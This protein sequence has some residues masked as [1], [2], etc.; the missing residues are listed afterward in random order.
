MGRAWR[1][2]YKS[3]QRLQRIRNTM[4]RVLKQQ[5][6]LNFAFKKR[7]GIGLGVIAIG[8][9]ILVLPFSLDSLPSNVKGISVYLG[10]YLGIF[11][12]FIGLGVISTGHKFKVGAAGESRVTEVLAGF[13]KYWYIFND[14][15]V[16]RSQIDH[17]VVCPKGVYTIET[18]NYQ[19]TIHGNAEKPEWSQVIYSYKTPFYNPVKQGNGHSVSLSKYL[20]KN[21]FDKLWVNTIVVF[22]DPGV[23]LKVFSPKVPVIYLSELKEVFN[24][25]QQIMNP[26]QCIKIA[27][28]VHK[29][30][31]AKREKGRDVASANSG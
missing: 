22:T 7:K 15:F 16:G 26:D 21:G 4:A 24:K 20:R 30:I 9:V 19:G 14:M 29:L 18:K 8:S 31:H 28:C 27:T 5:K 2:E 3:S 13:P 6:S 23:K 17:I 25:Q 12:V 10:V 1:I 11:L